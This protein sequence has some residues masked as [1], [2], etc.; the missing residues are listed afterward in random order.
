MAGQKRRDFQVPEG[1]LG[2]TEQER[3]FAM[4]RRV[5]KGESEPPV[6]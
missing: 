4:L 6:M 2:D 3:I 5:R 1:R